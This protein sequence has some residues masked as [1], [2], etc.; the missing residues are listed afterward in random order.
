MPRSEISPSFLLNSS[1][2]WIA[3]HCLPCLNVLWLSK[4]QWLQNKTQLASQRKADARAESYGRVG[5]SQAE[6]RQIR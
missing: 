6:R 2:L 4:S 1:S 3:T 5:V